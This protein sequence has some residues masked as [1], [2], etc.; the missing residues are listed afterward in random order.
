MSKK[1]NKELWQQR[2][3]SLTTRIKRGRQKNNASQILFDYLVREMRKE[4]GND[5]IIGD[6]VEKITGMFCEI[7]RALTHDDLR[8]KPEEK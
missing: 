4:D 8:V 3:S 5:D 7:E 6:L 2:V 1:K